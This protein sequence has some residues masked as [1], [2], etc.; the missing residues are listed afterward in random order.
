MYHATKLNPEARIAH[1]PLDNALFTSYPP[2][3][4]NPPTDRRRHPQSPRP[5]RLELDATLHPLLGGRP[6]PARRPGH[7]PYRLTRSRPTRLPSRPRR[8]QAHGNGTHAGQSPRFRQAENP[9]PPVTQNRL[10]CQTAFPL[11]G[12]RPP[13]DHRHVASGSPVPKATQVA[14]GGHSLLGRSRPPFRGGMVCNLAKNRL[15]YSSSLSPR[16]EASR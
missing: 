2:P 5:T 13:D 11:T 3:H 10:V 16:K 4:G 1:H 15:P 12:P 14:R 7:A 6:I 8:N 9:P